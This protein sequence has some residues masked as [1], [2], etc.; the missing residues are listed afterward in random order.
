MTMSTETLTQTTTTEAP[1]SADNDTMSADEARYFETRGD[2]GPSSEPAPAPVQTQAPADPGQPPA[3]DLEGAIEIDEQGR[4]RDTRT[5]K[6]VPQK[7]LHAERERRKAAQQEAATFRED[8][9]RLK[10]QL[11]ILSQALQAPQQTAAPA[12]PAD[13]DPMPDP[14]QDIF[15]YVAW[16][17][18]E[19]QRI[20]TQLE[21]KT[22]G[23]TE[24]I[25]SRDV[26]EHYRA[27]ANAFARETPDF[28]TAYMHLV[29][30][31]DAELQFRGITDAGQRQQMIAQMEKEEVAKARAAGKRPAEVIYNLAKFRGYSAAVQAAQNPT[32]ATAQTASQPAPAN[33]QVSSV[34]DNVARGQQIATSLSNAPGGPSNGLTAEAIAR[35]SD[36]EFAALPKET[37]RRLLGG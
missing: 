34:L 33:P 37:L 19:L 25:E 35:M 18:R 30:T 28:G 23:V 26:A 20:R 32:A 13:A 11:E 12:A 14:Q 24:R 36:P 1:A 7:A 4:I 22:R 8:A 16:Q 21:E 27:D 9:T 3:D 15:G 2:D 10:T 29:K 31:V 5:G 17:Q 6:F